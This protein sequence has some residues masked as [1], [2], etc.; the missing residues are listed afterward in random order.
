MIELGDGGLERCGS[1]SGTKSSPTRES[2]YLGGELEVELEGGGGQ[3]G[4]RLA[5]G[6]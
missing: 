1:D 3:G 5:S 6:P 2:S 4:Q